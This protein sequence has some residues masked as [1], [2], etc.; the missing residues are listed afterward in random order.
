MDADDPV[1]IVGMAVEAPGD[2]DSAESYWQLLSSGHEAL[3]AFP[4]DRGWAVRDLLA[5]SRRDG[6]KRIHNRGGF[7]T[8]AALFDPSFFGISPR[9]AVAMAWSTWL[10]V[11]ADTCTGGAEAHA[12]SASNG[13]ASSR[14]K[15]GIGM[16]PAPCRGR[17]PAQMAPLRSP[18]RV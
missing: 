4:E 9:E 18:R 12:T 7:L 14:R 3:T 5:G 16:P 13:A 10:Q 15:P 2:V 6:F 1:V 8:G 11:C 17:G